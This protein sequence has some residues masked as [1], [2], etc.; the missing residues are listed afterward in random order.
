MK[1]G[2]NHFKNQTSDSN[3]SFCSHQVHP[4][5]YQTQTSAKSKKEEEEEEKNTKLNSGWSGNLCR[6]QKYSGKAA[7]VRK[8]VSAH[9]GCTTQSRME[10]NAGGRGGGAKPGRSC[11]KKVSG[12][13]HLRSGLFKATP[14]KR[15][16]SFHILYFCLR[17]THDVLRQQSF[18]AAGR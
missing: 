4:G 2:R 6:L 16:P 13:L 8:L 18:T 11:F 14:L 15:G 9:R 1:N 10:G 7:S 5:S 3:G 17:R 12:N